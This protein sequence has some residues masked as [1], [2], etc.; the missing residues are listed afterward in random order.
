MVTSDTTN[1][2]DGGLVVGQVSKPVPLGKKDEPRHFGEAQVLPSAS[3]NAG[4]YSS[5][6]N[7]LNSSVRMGTTLKRSATMP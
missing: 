6:F 7:F 2:G 4:I 3:D 5:A 1:L